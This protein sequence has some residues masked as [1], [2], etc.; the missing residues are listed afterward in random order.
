MSALV[1]P[2][3]APSGRRAALRVHG[4]HPGGVGPLAQEKSS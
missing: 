4:S 1:R 2:L 3:G